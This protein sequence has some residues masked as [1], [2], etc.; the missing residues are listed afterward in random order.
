MPDIPE[1]SKG[2]WQPSV[3]QA[4]HESL[5]HELGAATRRVKELE[6]RLDFQSYS[7][8]A[9]STAIYPREHA[10]IY[11]ML[12]LCGESG[13]AAEKV[14]KKLRDGTWD[15][16]S[17]IKEMGDVLWY[18]TNLAADLGV[19]LEEVARRNLE[20]LQSRKE[21]GKLQGTGDNR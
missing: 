9:R 8:G 14:K 16:D 13:E 2:L 18:L 5:Y 1:D 4:Q 10:I 7:E 17:F 12:G 19:S 6:G 21:R 3:I 15:Q 20:K 11:P